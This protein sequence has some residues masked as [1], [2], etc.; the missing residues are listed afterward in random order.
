MVRLTLYERIEDAK[1]TPVQSEMFFPTEQFGAGNLNNGSSMPDVW[2]MIGFTEEGKPVA[3]YVTDAAIKIKMQE[4]FEE[5][6]NSISMSGHVMT[7]DDTKPPR[8]AFY[9]TGVDIS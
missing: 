2:Q 8:L 6:T 4:K 1:R 7:L 9:A 3:V 5:R